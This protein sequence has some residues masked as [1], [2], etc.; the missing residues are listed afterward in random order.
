MDGKKDGREGWMD[1]WTDG[2]REEEKDGL[3]NK[4]SDKYIT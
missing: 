3:L 2:G 4:S 1:G